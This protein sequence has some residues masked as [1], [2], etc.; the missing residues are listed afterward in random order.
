LVVAA[1]EGNPG[2][3]QTILGNALE[4]VSKD[5]AA[6]ILSGVYASLAQ[7]PNPVLVALGSQIAGS[8]NG[9]LTMP[10]FNPANTVGIGVTLSSSTPGSK[11]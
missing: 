5:Q 2:L 6:D 8:T 3:A 11:P 9:V 1:I 7:S 4:G 10:T